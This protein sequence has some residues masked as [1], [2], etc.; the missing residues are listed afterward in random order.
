MYH[1]EGGE[2]QIKWLT[3]IDVFFLCGNSVL[4]ALELMNP[5]F[6]YWHGLSESLIIIFSLTGARALHHY[7]TNM[8][9]NLWLLPDGKHIEI[10]FMSAFMTPKTEKMRIMN[11]GYMADSRLLNVK[12]VSYQSGLRTIYINLNRNVFSPNKEH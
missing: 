10:E 7:S 8:V 12:A 4:L 6:G 1:C 11:F 9:N 5:F 3:R 2:N